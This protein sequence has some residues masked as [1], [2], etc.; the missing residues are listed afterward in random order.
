PISTG[1]TDSCRSVTQPI[2]LHGFK[3]CETCNIFRPPRSK[4]CQSCN[5]CVD[6]CVSV[7]VGV[8]VC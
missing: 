5:N 3:Y 2:G 7:C 8:S 6:R 1:L 4:H